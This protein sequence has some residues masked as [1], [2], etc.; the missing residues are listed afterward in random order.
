MR[1]NANEFEIWESGQ[2]V[3]QVAQSDPEDMNDDRSHWAG[4]AL[5]Q[6]VE[7]TGTDPEMALK[8]LLTDLMHWCD[9][10]GES[11]TS[12]L[13]SSTR[14]YQEEISPW[15]IDGLESL[16]NKNPDKS[17]EVKMPF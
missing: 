4:I 6:F 13:D 8:D 16:P 15:S 17:T 12:V 2:E 14:S 7:T 1:A 9:R 10:H 11:F 5:A 3:E